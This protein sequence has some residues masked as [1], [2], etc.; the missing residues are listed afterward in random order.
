M[1]PS[2]LTPAARGST[3]KPRPDAGV[4]A[5]AGSRL[6]A[7]LQRP[8]LGRSDGAAPRLGTGGG[9]CSKRRAPSLRRGH[10]RPGARPHPPVA[11]TARRATAA[12]RSRTRP[13]AARAPWRLRTA[14]FVRALPDHV[15]LDRV[16][17]GRAW[18]PL[19]GVLL[20]GI[21]AMQVEVL[22]LNAGIGRSLERG[23]ALQAQNELLRASVAQ[24]SDEQRIERMAAQMGM[25]M[26]APG[27]L[28]FVGRGTAA[29]SGPWAA[30]TPPTPRTSSPSCPRSAPPPRAQG[31][32][33][34]TGVGPGAD[35]ARRPRRC[36]RGHRHRPATTA[37]RPPRAP[38]PRA[39]PSAGH[40]IRGRPRPRA[41]QP[42]APR[43]PPPPR[44]PPQPRSAPAATTGQSG[45]PRPAAGWA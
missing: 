35:A 14:A 10:R 33:V 20:A 25:L 26:P 40:D 44:P 30:S 8:P 36:G 4:A 3:K 15:L 32:S 19:L 21:V 6:R 2:A 27:Q 37:R 41:R 24:L 22:K 29:S 45:A 12:S 31:T 43:R 16:I 17:R 11:R 42:R 18:I 9:G 5:V 13:A 34:N 1:T 7:S 23:T 39:P 38:H 28:K